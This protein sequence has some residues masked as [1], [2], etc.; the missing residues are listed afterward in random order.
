MNVR[1]FKKLKYIIIYKGLVLGIQF[2]KLM[3]IG[4]FYFSKHEEEQYCFHSLKLFFL[5]FTLKYLKV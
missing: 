3:L 2:A 1:N 5:F 4:L